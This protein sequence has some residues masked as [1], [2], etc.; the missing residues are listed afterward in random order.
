MQV[1]AK[2]A[3]KVQESLKNYGIEAT[4]LEMPSSTRTANDAANSIGCSVEQIVKSL[5]FKIKNTNQSVLVLAS[6]PNRVNEKVIAKKIGEKITKADATFV[7]DITGYAIG[8]IPP[9]GHKQNIDMIFI[10][11]SLLGLDSLW[12][13]AG[14]PNSVFNIK[15]TD[16]VDI[17]S[18]T[19]ININ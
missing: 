19:I 16:L 11:D 6:G 17:T 5:I 3:I 2:S 10:D 4:V 15:P 7:R 12:A 1:H 18:G 8:G 9:V 14:T 13:A